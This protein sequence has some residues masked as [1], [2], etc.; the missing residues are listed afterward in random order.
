MSPIRKCPAS[1]LPLRERQPFTLLLYASD[2]TRFARGASLCML[3]CDLL[4]KRLAWIGVANAD[5]VFVSTNCRP[6]YCPLVCFFLPVLLFI[7]GSACISCHMELKRCSFIIQGTPSGVLSAMAV[8]TL[9]K[10]GSVLA[11]AQA[12]VS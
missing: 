1:G 9:R 4:P 11:F 7:P 6:A 8:V 10:H 2:H 3:L 12:S 5:G